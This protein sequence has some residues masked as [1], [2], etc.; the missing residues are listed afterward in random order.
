MA[1]ALHDHLSAEP[2]RYLHLGHVFD[3]LA[4][5]FLGPLLHAF[6]DVIRRHPRATLE[7]RTKFTA[8][9]LLPE[10]APPNVI[11]AF[12]LAP[13]R[14]ARLYEGGTA[15]LAARLGAAR[16][17]ARRGYRL[18]I[19]LDPVFI[20]PGWEREYAEL[21]STLLA[22]L[23]ADSIA[24]TV[25]GCFRGPAALIDRTRESDPDTALRQGEFVG[26][27][28]GKFGYPRP[29]RLRALRFLSSRL[30]GRFPIRFCFEDSS[31]T[32]DV[33]GREAP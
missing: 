3:P 9:H 6:L 10:A 22:A 28:S 31:A 33:F 4:Y 11:L 20:Y 29:L 8:L 24:D 16:E 7:I 21:C 25:V 1:A 27:G 26:I 5:P 23:P 32:A 17:G 19:R 18:G 2:D 13:H 15:S 30:G 12:S 14:I